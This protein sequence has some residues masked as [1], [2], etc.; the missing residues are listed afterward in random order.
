MSDERSLV[1]GPEVIGVL[2]ENDG[3]W[4]W[5]SLNKRLEGRL[6]REIIFIPQDQEFWSPWRFFVRFQVFCTVKESQSPGNRDG[7][8]QENRGSQVW[9]LFCR[10]F[11]V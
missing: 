6:A 4:V 10:G 5:K 1:F 9:N 11:S 2:H 3:L 7:I 8:A